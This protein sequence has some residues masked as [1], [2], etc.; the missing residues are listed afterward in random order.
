[1]ILGEYGPRSEMVRE[2]RRSVICQALRGSDYSA[3]RTMMNA[4]TLKGKGNILEVII[5]KRV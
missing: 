4:G 5:I 2:K 3:K 1:L